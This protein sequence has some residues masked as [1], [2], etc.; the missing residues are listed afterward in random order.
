MNKLRWAM[1]GG[2]WDVDMSTPVTIDGLARPV[3]GHPTIPLGL[4][5]GSRL[6]R[7]KQVDFF[8][9]FMYMP[10][11][12]SFS[13]AVGGGSGGGLF[14]QRVFAFPF[15]ENWF[16][17]LLGQFNVKKFVTS[18]KDDLL[19]QSDEF[20]L[21]DTMRN[22]LEDKSLYTLDMCSEILLSPDDT[23]QFANHNLTL[24][25]ASPGLFVDHRGTYWDVPLTMALDLASVASDAGPSYHLCINQNVG[26][27]KIFEGQ[28]NSDVAANILPGLHAKSALSY[29]TN[30]DLWRSKAPK[31]K[32]VQPYDAFLSNPHIS[33][34]GI[35]GA[36]VSASLGDNLAEAEVKNVPLD[37]KQFNLHARGTNSSISADAF[38]SVSL[39][40]QHGNF[41]R[42]FL[43][44][45]RFYAR[46]DF[47]SASKFIS[48]ASHLANNLYS[49]QTPNMD[50]IQAIC[51]S[52]TL[53]F[54][55]QIAGP[56]SFRVDSGVSIDLKNR[57]WPVSVKD[58]VFAAE[59][60]LQ[61]LGSAKATAWYS[62]KQ[63]EFMIELRFFE[64]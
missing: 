14:L 40:A 32:L 16:A 11:V 46:M 52:A 57:E 59:Y 25:A 60:A 19:N 18:V 5:R 61:V 44:L 31:I 17:T 42:L 48:G 62:P 30:V 28:P 27:P 8:Q 35:L 55:Q 13:G 33:V 29:K 1:D 56:I 50:A 9:K 22:R 23:L 58:P 37:F 36:V 21:L 49:S 45:T 20:S 43:D 3:P 51:P 41:Q 15:G 54:Q 53:S 63:K 10:F 38:A 26:D 34:S 24:E 7:P 39:S 12:P 64:K 6:S 47:P 4:S 2:F